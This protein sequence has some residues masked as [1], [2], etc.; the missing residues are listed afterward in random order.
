[1]KTLA[2]ASRNAKELQ[3]D[4]LTSIFGIAFPIVL[5]VLL[6]VI[7]SSIPKEAHMTL[8]EIKNL[9]GGISA[10]GLV[11]LSLFLHFWFQKTDARLLLSDF[12]LRPLSRAATYSVIQYRSFLW[13]YCKHLLPVCLR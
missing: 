8:F 2:F 7:N 1:M 11:F 5:L 4:V 9:T 10:F 12:T 6:S 13:L 3:R